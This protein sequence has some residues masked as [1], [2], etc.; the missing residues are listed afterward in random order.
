VSN[1]Q[2]DVLE[3]LREELGFVE[4]GGYARRPLA[5]LLPASFF[6]DSRTCLNFGYPYRAHPCGECLLYDFVPEAGRAEELPCHHIPLDAGGTTVEALEE[7]GDRKALEDK[8]KS[9]LRARVREIES[10]RYTERIY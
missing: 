2:R 3:T 7:R 5:P 10:A 8:V 4:R 1:D 6:Q 9:W